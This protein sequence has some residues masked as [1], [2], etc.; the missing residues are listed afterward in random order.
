MLHS[1]SPSTLTEELAKKGTQTSV[2]CSRKMAAALSQSQGK[3]GQ[4]HAVV[5]SMP[6]PP[7]PTTLQTSPEDPFSTELTLF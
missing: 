3:V 7:S 2:N 5:A 1:S 4:L 6:L